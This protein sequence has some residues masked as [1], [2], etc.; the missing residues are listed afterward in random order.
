[1]KRASNEL[2]KRLTTVS[3]VRP[4]LMPDQPFV[5]Y[6]DASQM[7]LGGVLMQECEGSCLCVQTVEDT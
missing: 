6:C 4:C 3:S 2:K 7:G 1:M 5:V